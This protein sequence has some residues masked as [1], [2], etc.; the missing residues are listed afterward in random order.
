MMPTSR[1]GSTP[2]APASSVFDPLSRQGH[3]VLDPVD[4]EGDRGSLVDDDDPH[5]VVK[6]RVGK[7]KHPPYTDHGKYR[8][9]KVGQ[10]E[11][12]AGPERHVSEVRHA[13]DFADRIKPKRKRL[14]GDAE[15]DKMRC[16]RARGAGLGVASTEAALWFAARWALLAIAA[17]NV[18]CE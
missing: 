2:P 13:Q 4:G 14:V 6:W 5:R 10:A 16:G 9:M 1:E 3:E 17:L 15:D 18:L 12:T 7:A 11:K 8:A